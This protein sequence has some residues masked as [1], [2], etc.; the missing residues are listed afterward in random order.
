ML[1]AKARNLLF[2]TLFK[3]PEVAHDLSLA[4]LKIANKISAGAL[5]YYLQKNLPPK[6]VTVMGL[7]FAN[8]VGLAAGLDKNADYLDD[9]ASFGFGFIEVGTVTRLPQAG[10][11]KPRLFRLTPQQAIINRF[12]FNSKGIDHLLRQV[13]HAAYNG[14]LGIN[15]GKNKI[16]PNDQ[17]LADYLELHARAYAFAD[18]IAVNI[19]SPNTPNL[20]DLQQQQALK[21]LVVPLKAQQ[22]RLA[23]RYGRYVPLAV[24]I[25]PDLSAEELKHTADALVGAHI[26]GIICANTTLSRPLANHGAALEAGG[27]SGAPLLALA[28]QQLQSLRQLVGKEM[29][30]IG[31]G[32]IMSGEDARAKI[33]AGADLVQ[34]Y[35]GLVFQGPQ[36]VRECVQHL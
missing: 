28:N 24:K 23:D 32:G 27:L 5:G 8:P 35:S 13:Q 29:P 10:N 20:R 26:D 36:L 7:E 3:N 30:I 4:S 9:L 31:V 11:P 14:I 12:G 22:A 1:Y 18:Y 34:I 25:A 2:A 16:T 17:A 15:I 33:Q 6:P 21:A 19:S